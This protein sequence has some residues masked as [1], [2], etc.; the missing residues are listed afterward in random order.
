MINN[1]VRHHEGGLSAQG[2]VRQQ[3]PCAVPGQSVFRPGSWW[4]ADGDA[5]GG[6]RRRRSSRNRCPSPPSRSIRG[7][8]GELRKIKGEQVA[9]RSSVYATRGFAGER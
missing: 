6:L 7:E 5:T 8:H 3:G 1:E 9:R 4:R 2:G